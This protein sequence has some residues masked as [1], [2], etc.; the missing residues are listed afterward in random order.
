MGYRLGKSNGTSY[1]SAVGLDKMEKYATKLGL[2][3]KSGVEITEREPHFSTESAVHSAIGQ[4]S[5]AYTPAQLA[6]YVSTVA[7]GGEK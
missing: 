3:M 5:N 6:R 2:N 7:N 4:G 1:D